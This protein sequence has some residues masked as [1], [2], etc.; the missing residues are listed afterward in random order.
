M[1]NVFHFLNFDFF[2]QKKKL[3]GGDMHGLPVPHELGRTH[4]SYLS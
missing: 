4:A 3:K 2:P 1:F